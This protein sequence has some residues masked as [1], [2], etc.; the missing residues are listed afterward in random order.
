MAGYLYAV[1]TY[2]IVGSKNTDGRSEKFSVR[3]ASKRQAAMGRSDVADDWWTP[4]EEHSAPHGGVAWNADLAG[5][6]R[7][8]SSWR[9]SGWI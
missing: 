1:S 3:S 2:P 4:R 5:M 8:S 7:V 6:T 9:R